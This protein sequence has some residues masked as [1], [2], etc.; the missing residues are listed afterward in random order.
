MTKKAKKVPFDPKVFLAFIVRTKCGTIGADVA[1]L[2]T[3]AEH[4]G[5]TRS[6]RAPTESVQNCTDKTD[7][8]PML[9]A[10]VVFLIWLRR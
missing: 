3:N 5:P 1:R 2:G 4:G 6:I 9:A 7:R 8:G 10:E